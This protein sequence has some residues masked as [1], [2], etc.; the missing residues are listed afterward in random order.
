MK[1]VNNPIDVDKVTE[2][3]STLPYAHTVGG[4]K[5][6]LPDVKRN[7]SQALEAM[8]HQTDQQLNQIREQI[9]L[10]AE[11]A[12]KIQAR[13]DL[14]AMIYQAKIGFKPNINHVYHLYHNED[15]SFVLSM[16][17][18]NEWK[19]SMKY[20]QFV[21]SVRLLADHTWDIVDK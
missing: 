9:E 15:D 8:E 20:D 21:Y 10:L 5:I 2:T 13:K 16:I 4:S 3:P 7:K 17:G 12:R 18:P 14:S 1:K 19:S 11:Q 6:T